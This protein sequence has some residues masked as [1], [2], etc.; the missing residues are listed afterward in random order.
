MGGRSTDQQGQRLL[1]QV[2]E[3][4][5]EL[6]AAGAVEGAMVAGER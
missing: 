2:R 4:A 6:G 3:R 5:Q 1:D